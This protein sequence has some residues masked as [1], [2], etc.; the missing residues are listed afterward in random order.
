MIMWKMLSLAAAGF[1]SKNNSLLQFRKL[2][3]ECVSIDHFR[4]DTSAAG[5]FNIFSNGTLDINAIINLPAHSST[6][7]YK[8]PMAI[9]EIMHH[10]S[11][12]EPF[13][14]NNTISI[15]PAAR[16]N[17]TSEVLSIEDILMKKFGTKERNGGHFMEKEDAFNGLLS[18][19]T[20]FPMF[21]ARKHGNTNSV[22]FWLQVTLRN[23][24][25]EQGPLSQHGFSLGEEVL[26][27]FVT[28]SKHP[29]PISFSFEMNKIADFGGAWTPYNSGLTR[30][31]KK[32]FTCALSDHFEGERSTLSFYLRFGAW[33]ASLLIPKPSLVFL[34]A[35]L[36]TSS[37]ETA[38]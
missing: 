8:M 15:L 17:D 5:I 16:L 9:A 36:S 14:E 31:L 33:S 25:L 6:F 20:P 19:V 27:R 7:I 18:N 34:P 2:F 22:G 3:V 38:F 28:E 26:L 30:H 4:E 21:G 24:S 35:I 13:V 1:I 11:I 37:K 10:H 29:I 32:S 23:L 12:E